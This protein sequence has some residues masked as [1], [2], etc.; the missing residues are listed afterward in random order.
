[1]E[2]QY[3]SCQT[4]PRLGENVAISHRERWKD[5][6]TVCSANFTFKMLGA[7]RNQN[8][9]VLWHTLPCCIEIEGPNFR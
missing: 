1:M 3:G 9:F 4:L 5:E 7:S 8:N 6:S 2:K